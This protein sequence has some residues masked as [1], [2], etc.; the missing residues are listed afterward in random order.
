MATEADWDAK[1]RSEELSVPAPDPFLVEALAAFP[2]SAGARAA[3]IAC[4]GGRHAVLLAMSGFRVRAIDRSPEALRLCSDRAATMGLAVETVRLDLEV[5][6]VDLGDELYDLVAVFNYLHRP[7]I[8]ALRR[9][10]RPGG[11]VVYKT[12]TRMQLRFPSGPRNPD[13]L[14]DQAE[15]PALFGGFRHL[16]YRET[17]ET[18]A[19]AALVAQRP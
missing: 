11:V 16:L 13:F 17:C 14:L 3:D 8:P 1:Y 19:T 2:A 9:S 6:S 18:D 5:P 10:V 7:L 4:G 15:L 12:Y